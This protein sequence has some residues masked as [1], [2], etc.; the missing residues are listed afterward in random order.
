MSTNSQLQY[1][2]PSRRLGYGG[3]I[4][5]VTGVYELGSSL[6][7]VLKVVVPSSLDDYSFLDELSRTTSLVNPV[8]HFTHF[9]CIPDLIISHQSCNKTYTAAFHIAM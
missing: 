3:N 4:D 8:Q 5:F 7:S 1:R 2:T 6:F 9:N